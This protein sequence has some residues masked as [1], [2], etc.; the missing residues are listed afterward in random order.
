MSAY[1]HDYP[2]HT[3][4]PGYAHGDEP[5]CNASS[6]PT[7]YDVVDARASR[8]GFLLGGLAA[9]VTGVFAAGAGSQARAQGVAQKP[10]LMGF[11]PV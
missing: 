9:A 5:P 6:N 10:S 7:F 3:A 11:K 4:T 1:E 8:R 2:D